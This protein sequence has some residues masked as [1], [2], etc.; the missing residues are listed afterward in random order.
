MKNLRVLALCLV[1]SAGMLIAQAPTTPAPAPHASSSKSKV[2]AAPPTAAEIADAK[3]KGLVW[4]NLNT[5][6]YHQ[7][8]ASQYGTTKNGIFMTEADAK[9]AGYRAAKDAAPKASKAATSK[10]N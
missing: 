2:Q 7:S 10:P 4:V 6:V 3:S 1:A 9:T 5:K 8:S